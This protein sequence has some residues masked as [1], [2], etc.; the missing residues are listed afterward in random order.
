MKNFRKKKNKTSIGDRCI[1]LLFSFAV[2]FLIIFLIISNFKIY[3]R[4]TDLGIQ[5]EEKKEEIEELSEKIKGIEEFEADDF[6]DDYRLEKI[7]RE[8]LLLKKEGEEVIFITLPEETEDEK[9]EIKKDGWL[10]SIKNIITDK[11]K[12]FFGK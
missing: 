2:L 11:I 3:Q 9:E 10:A 5:I 4:R 1:S 7:A 8:Q 12:E 6:D